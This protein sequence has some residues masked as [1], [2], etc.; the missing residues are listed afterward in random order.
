MLSTKNVVA[1][2]NDVP[3]EWVFENYLQLNEKLTG[4]GINMKSPFSTDFRPSLYVYVSEFSNKYKFKD[5]STGKN[6]DGVSLVQS[7]F[8]YPTR[9]R[10][11]GKILYDYAEYCKKSPEDYSKRE[12]KIVKRFAIIEHSV[13]CWTTPDKKFWSQFGIGTTLLNHYN[14]KPILEYR[15]AREENG[16]LVTIP[17]KGRCVYGYF[18][19]DGTLYKI[20]QPYSTTNKFLKVTDYI[21][22]TDQ[23]TMS[24]P[25]LVLCSSLKDVM[26]FKAL[27]Y[28]KAEAV[29]P[30]SENSLIPAHIISSYLHKYKAV[31]TL[32]DNDNAG[33]LSMA[34]YYEHFKLS[35]VLLPMS[36]DLTDSIRDFTIPKVRQELTPLLRTAL[37]IIT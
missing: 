30:D 7:L 25:Y 26:G 15:L 16:N 4:Q 14:V 9:G 5:F 17:I 35:S 34:R 18:R 19:A 20:Y 10:A 27:G 24:V 6:G 22:G 11:A 21:Q 28:T 8:E 23:L 12:F 3:I 33:K 2:V 37:K 32:F 13:R 1:N 31:C 29:A 36:K